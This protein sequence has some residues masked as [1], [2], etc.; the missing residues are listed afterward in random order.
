[1]SRR[2]EGRI[3]CRLIANRPVVNPVVGSDIMNL[4]L[5][6]HRLGRIHIMRQHAI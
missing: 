2:L 3:R 5:G 1:M 4:R 6:F